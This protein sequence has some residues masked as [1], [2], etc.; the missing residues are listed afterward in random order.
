MSTDTGV[1]SLK[2]KKVFLFLLFFLF[3]EFYAFSISNNNKVAKA[4]GVKVDGV[5]GSFGNPVVPT[6]ENMTLYVLYK[7]GTLDKNANWNAVLWGQVDRIGVHNQLAIS[8]F[9]ATH[10]SIIWYSLDAQGIAYDIPIWF[11]F[12]RFWGKVGG[13]WYKDY[14]TQSGIAKT[15]YI[16]K[17][18]DMKWEM[19]WTGTLVFGSYSFPFYVGVQQKRDSNLVKLKTNVTTPINLDNYAIEYQLYLNPALAGDAQKNVKW[20]RVYWDNASYNDYNILQALNLT[21]YVNS[22]NVNSFSFLNNDKSI[23]I[24]TFDFTDVFVNATTRM[25]EIKSVTLPNGANTYVVNVGCIFGA[26]NAGETFVIDPTWFGTQTVGGTS[27]DVPNRI[28]GLKATPA[29]TPVVAKSITVYCLLDNGAAS[30]KQFKYKASLYRQNDSVLV[31]S[32]IEA[33]KSVAG[34][35]SWGPGWWGTAFVVSKPTITNIAYY[36]V[37]WFNDPA[38]TDTSEYMYH[39]ALASGGVYRSLAYGAFPNPLAGTVENYNWSIY[40]SYEANSAP[41]IGVPSAPDWDDS[42]NCYAQKKSYA[43]AVHYTDVDGYTDFHYVEL[44]VKTGGN[45]TR[46]EFQYH[47]DDNTVSKI[48]GDNWTLDSTTVN[49]GRA[50]DDINANWLFTA[51][52]NATEEADLDFLFLAVDSVG[53]WANSLSDQNFDVVTR[54]VTSGFT[55]DV[56]RI[57][58][59]GTT[60][61]NGTVYYGDDPG[62]NTSSTSYPPDAEFTQI[63]IHDSGDNVVGTDNVIVT[64]YFSTSFAIPNAVQANPYHVYINLADADGTDQDALDGDTTAVVG[65]RIKVNVASLVFEDPDGRVNAVTAGVYSCTAQSEYDG[66]VLGAV[67]DSLSING[68]GF[69]YN[70]TYWRCDVIEPV[71]CAVTLNGLFVVSETTYG[72]TAGNINGNSAVG[73]WDNLIVTNIQPVQY[74]GSG[75]YKYEAQLEYGYDLALIDGGYVDLAYPNGTI[76]DQVSSNATGWVTFVVGQLNSTSG[77]FVLYG[78][79]ETAYSITVTGANQTFANYYWTLTPQDVAGNSLT[80]TN[81]NVT[82]GATAVWSGTATSVYVPPDTFNLTVTWLQ[83]LPVNST[84]NVPIVGDTTTDLNCTCYPYVIGATRYWTAS[85]A[86]ITSAVYASYLLTVKFSCALDSYV[87]VA[88]YTT[89][90]AY[91]LNVTYNMTIAFASGYLVMPH[92]GNM[93]IVASYENWAGLYVKYTD[94]TMWSIGWAGYQLNIVTNGTVGDVGELDVYCASRGQPV[95]TSGFTVTSYVGGVFTGLYTF[96]DTSATVSLEWAIASSDP[97]GETTQAPSLFITLAF[98]FPETVQSG[99]TVDGFL[100]VSWMGAT[101]IYIWSVIVDS[102]YAKDWELQI[103]RLPWTLETLM[104][105]GRAQVPVALYITG[106]LAAGNYSVPCDVTF[107]TVEGVSKTVR[108]ILTFEVTIPMAEVPSTLVYVFLLGLGVV[109]TSGLFLGTQ[110][111]RRLSTSS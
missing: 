24:S 58:I 2:H 5:Q 74:L 56:P 82:L 79:N 85:N 42:D 95:T 1:F 13:I 33:T 6:F 52:W 50:L 19:G 29:D 75:N 89:Y 81:H 73:I 88:S 87:L 103:T 65:D 102:D 77:T 25:V 15:P 4:D 92:F 76:L 14:L 90:P 96:T 97:T 39:D 21:N 63:D 91:V 23:E 55:N 105:N 28:T 61:I 71:P 16:D 35:G 72:I 59:A 47:E 37:A 7:N 94:R 99:A 86:T 66:H 78:E 26:L 109:V 60:T 49:F 110:K 20:V 27:V 3:S 30:S 84:V 107:N 54:L 93:T 44:L 22:F 98:T 57:N 64:G 17:I 108:T 10:G 69:V 100:N 12:E 34:F 70:G 104:Q 68:Y 11:T 43:F 83:N 111:R 38:T 9:D 67:G 31:G 45:V 8:G 18:S 101:K 40:C 48:S 53:N 106:T 36:I 80:N 62:S 41:T 51:H 32:T 46:A